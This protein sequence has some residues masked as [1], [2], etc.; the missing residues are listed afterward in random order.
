MFASVFVNYD[1]IGREI[2]MEMI[3]MIQDISP[4]QMDVA[5]KNR[6]IT[7]DD[8]V[9]IVMDH[10][11]LVHKNNMK[12]SYPRF[13]EVKQNLAASSA[14]YL[15]LFAIDE[16]SYY[17]YTGQNANVLL[18]RFDPL[19]RRELF[20]YDD[21]TVGHIAYTAGHIHDWYQGNRY[22]GRCGSLMR[23]SSHERAMTCDVCHLIKYPQISPVVIVAIENG[24]QMLFTKYA[25][26]E[27]DRYALVAGFVEIGETLED[28]VHREVMEEVGIGVKNIRY[29][30]S[31]PWG[32][33]G[34]LLAGFFAE[35]DGDEQVT[36]DTEELKEATWL[37]R[38]EMPEVSQDE[39]SLTRTMMY[40]WY[41]RT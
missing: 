26:R 5:Y 17:L 28:A 18:G 36:L 23:L 1:I 3:D 22:C 40:E 15:Y 2:E 31:Q 21:N 12:P 4:K 37:T 38:E 33:T 32:I 27:Y 39:K 9:I 10:D 13:S 35:L 24:D 14:D 25:N 41:S 6:N 20:N 7:D 29:F 11:I 34:G 16:H 19:S 30:K 8:Y